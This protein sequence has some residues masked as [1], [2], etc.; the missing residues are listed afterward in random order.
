[1]IEPLAHVE[2]VSGPNRS[3]VTVFGEI[4]L[5]NAGEI[6]LAIERAFDAATS[7]IIDMR[8][9]LFMD[10]QGVRMLHDLAQ[11]LVGTGISLEIVAPADSVAGQVLRLTQMQAEVPLRDD[12]DD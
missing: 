6:G 2:V 8:S 3:V 11:R 12:L 5:S 4:D 7:V 1:M 9:V 10:S